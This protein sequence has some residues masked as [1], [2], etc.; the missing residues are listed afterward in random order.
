MKPKL[1]HIL[2]LLFLIGIVLLSIGIGTL[3]VQGNSEPPENYK[4][5]IICEKVFTL[6]GHQRFILK[7]KDHNNHFKFKTIYVLNLD[8]QKYRLGDTI[9]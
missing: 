1:I 9:K 5:A 7:C 6:T 3:R 4:G 2:F 8:Y